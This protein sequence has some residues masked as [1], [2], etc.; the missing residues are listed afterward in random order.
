MAPQFYEVDVYRDR[1]K[2]DDATFRVVI[3]WHPVNAPAMERLLNR[4]IEAA[5]RENSAL[6]DDPAAY[7]LYAYP[8]DDRGERGS[9]QVWLWRWTGGVVEGENR[10]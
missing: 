8:V 5:A 4:Y 9:R 7:A 6:N 2:V 3:D 1:R 10:R